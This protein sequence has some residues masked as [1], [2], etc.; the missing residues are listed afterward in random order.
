MIGV[1]LA[2]GGSRRMGRDKALVEVAGRPM[3]DWVA[4]AIDP[5]C[6]LVV[7]SGR[8]DPLGDLP[9]IADPGAAQ[10]GPLAGLVAAFERFADE[11]VFLA[12]VDQPWLRSE[13]AA[14]LAGRVEDLA[15]APVDGG[16][17]Q[18]TCAVYPPGLADVAA[19]ELAA[20]GS[21]QS[22]LD[23]TSFMPVVA[24]HSWDEDGRSWFSVDN[25]TDI[26]TGLD[27][28]GPPAG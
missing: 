19:S 15:V 22:L 28:F 3:F 1:I 7:V 5:A 11:P 14:H 9:T 17:R 8:Y 4:R 21:L 13:T 12:G 27:R 24:W 23:V 16:V 2:G 6:E 25:P 20:G 10:R 18:T 26:E